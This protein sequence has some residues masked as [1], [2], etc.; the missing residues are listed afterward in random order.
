MLISSTA[1]V[2]IISVPSDP[3][4]DS[5]TSTP[6]NP[7]SKNLVMRSGS[8]F[9]SRSIRCTR[10]RTSRAANSAIASRNIASSS[11]STVNGG[12]AAE[13]SIAME[14]L[15]GVLSTPPP[16]YS[17]QQPNEQRGVSLGTTLVPGSFVRRR[18]VHLPLAKREVDTATAASPLGEVSRAASS[19]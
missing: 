8:I 12:R 19:R 18:N 4:S 1:S 14:S 7:I 3:P 15:S 16:V 9:P 13:V 11:E 10:G 2:T 17:I 6:I 5:G